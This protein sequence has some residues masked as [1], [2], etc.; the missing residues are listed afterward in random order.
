[1]SSFSLLV[2][3]APGAVRRLAT[4][5]RRCGRTRVADHAGNVVWSLPGASYASLAS[6]AAGRGPGTRCMLRRRR[7][8]LPPWCCACSAGLWHGP[9]TRSCWLR[10]VV[11][12]LRNTCLFR[13]GALLRRA[14]RF[15]QLPPAANTSSFR[16]RHGG[17]RT[18]QDVHG[19]RDVKATRLVWRGDAP[20]ASRI[21][22]RRAAALEGRAQAQHGTNEA[23]RARRTAQPAK[24]RLLEA[25]RRQ[26]QPP[27]GRAAYGRARARRPL[28]SESVR[29]HVA[30]SV[31]PTSSMSSASQAAATASEVA[32]W[33]SVA[34]SVSLICCISARP[35]KSSECARRGPTRDGPS[36][37]SFLRASSLACFFS[38]ARFSCWSSSCRR[39]VRSSHQRQPSAGASRPP[40][41]F[42]VSFAPRPRSGLAFR[43]RGVPPRSCEHHRGP[44]AI[45][46]SISRDAPASFRRWMRAVACAGAGL[47]AAQKSM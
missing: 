40:P 25:A 28:P 14:A 38:S 21:P 19:S 42:Q 13:S 39:R 30:I 44:A 45:S 27:P 5:C 15:V 29:V 10:S 6:R 37:S 4:S 11:S 17:P 41:R 43:H 22:P 47:E 2:N 32:S 34:P 46:A 20:A 23:Q 16:A 7:S 1:M 36:T 3:V 8:V 31:P 33:A 18:V 35:S 24:R 12:V 9:E 26:H